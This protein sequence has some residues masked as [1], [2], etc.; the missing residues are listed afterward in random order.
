MF[1]LCLQIYLLCNQQV[2]LVLIGIKV[3][4]ESSQVYI[5]ISKKRSIIA[6]SSL[7]LQCRNK[8]RALFK[9][10]LGKKAEWKKLNN[11]YS[12]KDLQIRKEKK[13]IGKKDTINKEFRIVMPHFHKTIVYSK[14]ACM[15]FAQGHIQKQWKISKYHT[16]ESLLTQQHCAL[17]TFVGSLIWTKASE[18]NSVLTKTSHEQFLSERIRMDTTLLS[19]RPVTH[20]CQTPHNHSFQL[21]YFLHFSYGGC[22][23]CKK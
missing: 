15:C 6:A 16:C 17:S 3:L 1:S 21:W 7:D 11:G 5:C 14:S 2:L 20:E 9:K 22:N 13:T 18:P 8:K 4:Y 19:P 12:T 10:H 23:N